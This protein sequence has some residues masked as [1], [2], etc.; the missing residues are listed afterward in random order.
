M[1]TP[2]RTFISSHAGMTREAFLATIRTPHL[3]LRQRLQSPATEQTQTRSTRRAPE[4]AAPDPANPVLLPVAKDPNATVFTTMIT[5]GRAPNNDII[6]ADSRVS[7]LQCFF[8]QDR[9]W[10]TIGDSCST[11]GT[12]VD[13]KDVA[14]DGA[15]PLLPH[16]RICLAGAIDVEFLDPEMLFRL[17]LGD[18]LRALAR[19]A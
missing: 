7:R 6:V 4:S 15:V 13:G 17:V 16:A 19:R 2:F 10:W 12:R 18:G 3:L 11:N 8:R 5:L 14:K 1:H 9:G